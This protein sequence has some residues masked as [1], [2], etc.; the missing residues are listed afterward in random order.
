MLT[1]LYKRLETVRVQPDFMAGWT[2]GRQLCYN[3][4]NINLAS[5][6]WQIGSIKPPTVCLC[7]G[8]RFDDEKHRMRGPYDS[9]PYRYVC[10][11]CWKKSYMFFPDK[12]KQE[13]PSFKD[14]EILAKAPIIELEVCRGRKIPSRLVRVPVTS[15]RLN[16]SNP[17]IR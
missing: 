4:S 5:E 3:R 14:D 16:P 7:C 15:L 12:A 1:E 9:G 2:G 17:R 11:W 13:A 8:S 10:E 6:A